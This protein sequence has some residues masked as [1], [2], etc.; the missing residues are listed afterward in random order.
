MFTKL[1]VLVCSAHI[2]VTLQSCHTGC[3]DKLSDRAV[4]PLVWVSTVSLAVQPR[5]SAWNFPSLTVFGKHHFELVKILTCS[6]AVPQP[7][8][9]ERIRGD[10]EHGE[11]LETWVWLTDWASLNLPC[12]IWEEGRKGDLKHICLKELREVQVWWYVLKCFV[13]CEMLCK[14]MWLYYF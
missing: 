8:L 6:W 5:I 14:V 9:P 13:N 3:I 1:W 7:L 4:W 10:D 12:F 2:C 11:L